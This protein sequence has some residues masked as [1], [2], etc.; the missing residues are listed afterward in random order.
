MIRL[1]R[2][3]ASENRQRSRSLR[4]PTTRQRTSADTGVIAGHDTPTRRPV[5]QRSLSHAP[6]CRVKRHTRPLGEF[7]PSR[8]QRANSVRSNSL[9]N[10]KLGGT[11]A[12]Q[13][14]LGVSSGGG[15]VFTRRMRSFIKQHRLATGLGAASVLAGVLWL[16]FGFFAVQ[17]L[18]ID[19]EVAE[20]LPTFDQ[21]AVVSTTDVVP[22][23]VMADEAM[24][25]DA[26][27]DATTT[28]PMT[29]PQMADESM[30]E[31]AMHRRTD[32]QPCDR[33]PATNTTTTSTTDTADD[34]PC[35]S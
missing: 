3:G 16:T 18:W 29:D 21:P 7:T 15:V 12:E 25:T 35:S 19:D 27:E 13:R 9:P 8:E 32:G 34:C 30:T 5:S 28:D 20:A 6:V 22:S 14:L 2:L 4:T 33:H 1:R 31:G 17:T 24:T 23:D 26:T 11:G 10:A